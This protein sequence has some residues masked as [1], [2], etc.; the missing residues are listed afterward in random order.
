VRAAA[1]RQAL[2]RQ[3]TIGTVQ[4][5][6]TP[7]ED[8]NSGR[9][10]IQPSEL[11]LLGLLSSCAI[12]VVGV[13]LASLLSH[14][15]LGPILAAIGS[16][17]AVLVLAI[18]V[19]KRWANRLAWILIGATLAVCHWVVT[20]FGQEKVSTEGVP[21]LLVFI[22]V[23]T[24]LEGATFS[25]HGESRIGPRSRRLLAWGCALLLGLIIF[26][27]SYVPLV[28]AIAYSPIHNGDVLPGIASF[29][30]ALLLALLTGTASCRAVLTLFRHRERHDACSP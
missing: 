21:L 8:E 24:L 20:G 26:I 6:N 17:V 19:K 2:G 10:D 11:A 23:V 16:G 3:E 22:L 12:V 25:A 29:A 4:T 30:G 9:K 1:Q 7:T 18:R 5:N 15:I 27:S 28:W 14:P 13:G